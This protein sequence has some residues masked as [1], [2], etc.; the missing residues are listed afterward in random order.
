MAILLAGV[1]FMQLTKQ[2][3][4]EVEAQAQALADD[5]ARTCFSVL[6]GQQP[7]LDLPS[8][9]AGSS[10]EVEIDENRS[11]FIVWITGGTGTGKSYWTVANIDLR[12]ENASFTP[13]GR[14]TS[15]VRVIS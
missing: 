4:F 9:I 1:F 11:T 15:C 10:Y 12:V 3:E 14:F 13:G 2:R 8:R 7:T 6:P 5:L